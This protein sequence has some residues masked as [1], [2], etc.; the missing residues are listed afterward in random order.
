MIKLV[1]LRWNSLTFTVLSIET[2][3]GI[4]GFSTCSTLI[5]YWSNSSLYKK[6]FISPIRLFKSPQ[7]NTSPLSPSS[8]TILS[9]VFCWHFLNDGIIIEIELNY[10]IVLV[11][12]KC[13]FFYIENDMYICFS[14]TDK[15]FVID[16]ISLDVL[17]AQ[18]LQNGQFDFSYF[19]YLSG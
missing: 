3:F 8:R 6:S 4:V 1:L 2:L 5:T 17:I 19:H 13:D 7:T 9:I 18:F 15:K 12:L 11:K 14:Y 10:G 16:E